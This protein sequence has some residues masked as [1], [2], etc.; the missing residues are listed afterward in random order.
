MEQSWSLARARVKGKSVTCPVRLRNPVVVQTR[1]SNTSSNQ[2]AHVTQTRAVPRASISGMTL[3]Q[4]R[5]YQV[6]PQRDPSRRCL[7][8]LRA[9]VKATPTSASLNTCQPR[10]PAQRCGLGFD[11]CAEAPPDCCPERASPQLA[12]T[13]CCLEPGTYIHS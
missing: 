1:H 4:E 6:L 9:A 11:N 5:L 7:V 10:A 8:L 13:T 3:E 2:D 12:C